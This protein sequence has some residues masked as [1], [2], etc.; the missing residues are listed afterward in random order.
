MSPSLVLALA[1]ALALFYLV[2]PHISVLNGDHCAGGVSNN[3]HMCRIEDD[4]Q[5]TKNVEYELLQQDEL[6]HVT[7]TAQHFAANRHHDH[8]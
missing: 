7:T 1:L 2:S 3:T 4:I 6:N 5:G 8:T